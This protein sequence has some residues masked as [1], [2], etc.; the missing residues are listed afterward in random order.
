MD[1][2]E[3]RGR[4]YRS[5]EIAEL[6]KIADNKTEYADFIASSKDDQDKQRKIALIEEFKYKRGVL[7]AKVGYTA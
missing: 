6:N 1:S 7:G 5:A 2:F 3:F 4:T